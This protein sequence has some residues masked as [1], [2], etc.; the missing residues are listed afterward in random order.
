MQ[1]SFREFATTEPLGA[2]AIACRLGL[3]DEMKI[4]SS[5][6][7]SIHL[8]GLAELPDEFKFIAATEYHRLIPLHSKYR[9]EVETIANSATRPTVSRGGLSGFASMA[10]VIAWSNV[11]EIVKGGM[12]VNYESFKLAWKAKY[13]VDPDGSDVHAIFLSILEK[14]NSLNLTV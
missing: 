6:T 8:S 7:T 2:Y 10:N 12:P 3:K 9:K 14:A 13:D 11:A 1:P 4:T 5:H